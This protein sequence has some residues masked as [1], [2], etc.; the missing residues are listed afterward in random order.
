MGKQRKKGAGRKRVGAE[1]IPLNMPLT[2]T[3]V[4]KLIG[5]SFPTVDRMIEEGVL[6][7]IK[8]KNI[9]GV[10]SVRIIREKDGR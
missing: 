2:R 6:K 1:I 9:V 10:E 5:C 3:E 8:V 7:K 4:A